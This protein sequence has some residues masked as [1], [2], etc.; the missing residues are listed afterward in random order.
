MWRA[1]AN[2]EWSCCVW[3]AEL[4]LGHGG[5]QTLLLCSMMNHW[6][7]WLVLKFSNLCFRNSELNNSLEMFVLFGTEIQRTSACSDFFLST[8]WHF[9]LQLC[10][11]L[12][13]VRAQ[14]SAQVHTIC[15]RARNKPRVYR[16]VAFVTGSSWGVLSPPAVWTE[17]WTAAPALT[18]FFLLQGIKE[19]SLLPVGVRIASVLKSMNCKWWSWTLCT[20]QKCSFAWELKI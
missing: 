1:W 6:Q 14:E 19:D 3:L 13:G 2:P 15:G 10:S 7:V 5:R 16:D 11:A 4:N 8:K 9:I 18:E 12:A 20:D 17:G